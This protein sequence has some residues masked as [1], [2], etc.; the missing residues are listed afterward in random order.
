MAWLS[1]D[2][3]SPSTRFMR[4]TGPYVLVDGTVIANDWAD[5]TDGNLAAAIHLTETGGDADVLPGV[6]GVW[7]H[8]LPDG[9]PGGSSLN[10]HCENWQTTDDSARGDAGFAFRTNLRW[11]DGETSGLCTSFRNNHYC[12]QQ[13]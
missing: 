4:S 12:F 6:G 2:T 3:G 11:T 9:T 1:D 13:S 10:V 7:T 5:L 8:T